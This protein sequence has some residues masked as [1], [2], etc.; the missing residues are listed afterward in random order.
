M[1]VKYILKGNTIVH[2]S[3]L[4]DKLRKGQCLTYLDKNGGPHSKI[5]PSKG[6]A[7]QETIPVGFSRS[8]AC[9]FDY[10]EFCRG[11]FSGGGRMWTHV[12]KHLCHLF[13]IFS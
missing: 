4:L 9:G 6:Q 2:V 12:M 3:H 5:N 11:G 1:P 7:K 13:L 10:G 8:V